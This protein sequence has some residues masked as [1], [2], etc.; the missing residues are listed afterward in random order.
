MPLPLSETSATI[1]SLRLVVKGFY[2]DS[3]FDLFFVKNFDR[4]INQIYKNAF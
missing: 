4:V 3:F 2:L 1:K